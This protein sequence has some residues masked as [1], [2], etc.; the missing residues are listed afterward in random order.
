MMIIRIRSR[1]IVALAITFFLLSGLCACHPQGSIGGNEA[2]SPAENERFADEKPA[3]TIRHF[4]LDAGI[5]NVDCSFEIPYMAGPSPA[6]DSFNDF[7]LALYRDFSEK[8]PGR[9]REI[10]ASAAPGTPSEENPY[11]DCWTARVQNCSERWISVSLS[12]DWYMGGVW[13]YGID[14]YT[15]DRN[16]GQRLFLDDVLPG[17]EEAIQAA[18][19][20]GLKEQYP[21]IEDLADAQGNTPLT[22]LEKIPIR[23]IDFYIAEGG[24][25]TVV[26]DKYEIAPGA[27]GMFTVEVD[28]ETASGPAHV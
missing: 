15:F 11:R 13:D 27:A 25:V 21:G 20:G 18:I 10:L 5:E 4:T 3:L 23:D 9:V 16:T 14:G 24:A 12:Y 17:T 6:A 1:R 22:A 28:W 26:F 2:V 7:F 8:E 19:A